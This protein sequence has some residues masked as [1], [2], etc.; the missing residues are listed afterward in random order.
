MAKPKAQR[1]REAEASHRARGE[2]QI[3]VWVPDPAK[4]GAEAANR[5]RKVAAEEC[6]AI[7]EKV[8]E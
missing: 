8:P 7:A 6:A 3:R 5:V 2:K 1:V 4:F